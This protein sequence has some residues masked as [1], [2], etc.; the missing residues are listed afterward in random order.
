M[1][2]TLAIFMSKGK[3]TANLLRMNDKLNRE[4]RLFAKSGIIGSRTFI[5]RPILSNPLLDLDLR[6]IVTVGLLEQ[7]TVSLGLCA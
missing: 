5:G 4:D 7:W 2:M 3:M 1:G 6:L